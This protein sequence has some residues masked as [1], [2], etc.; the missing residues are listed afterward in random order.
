MDR[1]ARNDG[2][3]IRRRLQRETRDRARDDENE[4]ARCGGERE[5]NPSRHVDL[6]R[7]QDWRWLE[8]KAIERMTDAAGMRLAP[9][10]HPT[11]VR[12]D[13]APA[14]LPPLEQSAAHSCISCACWV[15]REARFKRGTSLS[16][17]EPMQPGTTPI[18]LVAALLGVAAACMLAPLWAPLV[19]AAWFADLA[20][21]L[22]RVFE[23]LLGGRHRGAAAVVVLLVLT[24]VVPLG[25]AGVVLFAEGRE[26]VAQ[27]RGVLE[28]QGALAPAL[29]GNAPPSPPLPRDWADLIS[30]Y[31]ADAWR[32]ASTITRASTGA[33]VAVL[34]FVAALYTFAADGDRAFAWFEQRLPLPREAW[35]RF[36]RAF[37][38][39][40]RGLLIAGGGTALVQGA[41][42]AVAYLAIGI[43]RAL[44][45]G[46]LTA[47]CAIVPVVG[48]ALVWVPLTI[49]L[50]A[51]GQHW[52]AG[53][54]VMVGVALHSLVDN[55]VRPALARH[56]RLSLPAFVV[57]VSM[58][59]GVTILGASGALLGPLLVRLAVEGIEISRS[60]GGPPGPDR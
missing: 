43:P 48:T 19:L 11:D 5:K 59:G 29:L 14:D 9:D 45:L 16:C 26:L 40:G 39:T 12:R 17:S 58:I 35:A 41:V 56:G 50:L 23:K 20:L 13:R 46:L 53:V 47:L 7:V 21:P 33:V 6:H 28:H 30:R 3:R 15:L 36:A 1:S 24:V 25:A 31:G 8:G 51:T 57:L 38:E 27:I 4:C 37:R 34:V 54:V 44:L 52:R 2:R 55:V 22:V 18:R 32:A 60:S 49:E 10:G 42:A